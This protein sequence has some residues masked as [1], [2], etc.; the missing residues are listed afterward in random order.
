MKESIIISSL[1]GSLCIYLSTIHFFE[2]AAMLLL[3]GVYPGGSSA[4]NPQVMLLGYTV[5]GLLIVGVV[6]KPPIT[7]LFSRRH[8]HQRA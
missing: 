5:A 3:F 4:I 1:L 7:K 6:A 2:S 8:P